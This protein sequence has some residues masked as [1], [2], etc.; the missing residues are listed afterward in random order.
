MKEEISSTVAILT[1]LVL[2]AATTCGWLLSIKGLRRSTRPRW[3]QNCMALACTLCA[4]AGGLC[5]SVVIGQTDI[6]VAIVSAVL[7]AIFFVPAFIASRH[8]PKIVTPTPVHPVPAP[9]PAPAS[10]ILQRPPYIDSSTQSAQQ[11]APTNR[12]TNQP[13]TY[14]SA[15]IHALAA[16]DQVSRSNT[17]PSADDLAATYRFKYRKS[18]GTTS[19]RRMVLQG[20]SL[21]GGTQ[22]LKGICTDAH[23]T[24]TFRVDRFQGDLTNEETGEMFTA[25][26]LFAACKK[27][28]KVEQETHFLNTGG[29]GSFSSRN[30]NHRTP[31]RV[32][33]SS[34]RKWVT[35]VYFAGFRGSKYA[36][37]ERIAIS[38]GWH[39]RMQIGPTVD[40]VVANGQAG[41]KQ[42]A[43]AS[44]YGLRVIDEDEF[45]SFAK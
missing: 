27:R 38:S 1:M 45:R 36:E 24:R 11:D 17:T 13:K 20:G 21:D 8:K 25:A 9:A 43:Q 33:S 29:N 22:Y 7:S 2:L 18:D 40:Y 3:L 30:I 12:P 34:G 41:A 35:A 31:R 28:G 10:A 39:V 15:G 14:S 19:T 26:K 16:Q 23:Q 42:L 6:G 4:F 37:L 32:P 5:L 44:E